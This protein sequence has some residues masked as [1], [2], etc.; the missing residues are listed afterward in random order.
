MIKFIK[1]D[2]SDFNLEIATWGVFAGT[3]TEKR[4]HHTFVRMSMSMMK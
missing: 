4:Y 1:K 3:W 2:N